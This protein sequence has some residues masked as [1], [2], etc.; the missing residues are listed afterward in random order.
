MIC[1]E[2]HFGSDHWELLESQFLPDAHVGLCC[3]RY[4]HACMY[5]WIVNFILHDLICDRCQ[6][7]TSKVIWR[8][9]IFSYILHTVSESISPMLAVSNLGRVSN[10]AVKNSLQAQ[11]IDWLE[12]GL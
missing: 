11:F 3:L 6:E 1:Q 4:V 8:N 5:T 7:P 9:I 2:R 12:Y 10:L